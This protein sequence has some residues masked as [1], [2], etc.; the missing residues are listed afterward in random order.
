MKK[1]ALVSLSDKTGILDFAK[2]MSQ[3]FDFISTGGTRQHL[4][5]GGIKCTSVAQITG[6]EEILDGRVKTLHPKIHAAI[7]SRRSA[8]DKATLNRLK[9]ENIDMVVVN[10]YPFE[11]NLKKNLNDPEI[12]EFIDIGG[13]TML[14]AAAKNYPFVLPICDPADYITIAQ[15]W[16][17]KKEIPL[18]DRKKLAAKAF[19]LCSNLDLIIANHLSNT[20]KKY[21][22]LQNK[23]ELR[24]GE[25]PHQKG[26]LYSTTASEKE[27]LNQLEVL[28]G[29]SLSYNNYLDVQSAV[30]VISEFITN[31]KAP[32]LTSIIKHNN[33]CGLASGKTP[34]ESIQKAWQSD[35]VSAFGSIIAHNK[36]VNLDFVKFLL[37]PEILHSAFQWQAT[38]Y[39]P[40]KVKKKFF[41]ILIAP[42]YDSDALE[43]LKNQTGA[44]LLKYPLQKIA[45]KKT[46][47]VTKKTKSL[48]FLDGVVLE[49]E[50]DDVI[51]QNFL[52][53]TEKKFPPSLYPLARF[54]IMCCK[55]SKSNAISLVREY[56]PSCYQLLG[57]GFGQPN[58]I[59]ALVKLAVPKMQENLRRE[60]QNLNPK[61]NYENWCRMQTKN[62]TKSD[63]LL[64]YCGL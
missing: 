54:G 49:Q 39:L 3:D 33:P 15:T 60:Y 50:K 9:I 43:F 25:N 59:D 28:Q 29:K 10:F 34:Q 27:G 5:Q 16:A 26:W 20:S 21:F 48:H 57:A 32:H 4:E 35:E 58:R 1:K 51:E 19:V 13:P 63:D 55:N 17:K 24:Y 22:F 30:R 31:P 8:K 46:A 7:L 11:N 36:K 56:S 14:R 40:Q 2:Q 61:E 44:I 18:V 23:K 45:G 62:F 37:S 12:L 52:C 53:K 64:F 42:D 6:A 41:E 47:A 38:G